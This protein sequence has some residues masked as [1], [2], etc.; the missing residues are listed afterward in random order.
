MSFGKNYQH[1][2]DLDDLQRIA[3]SF[4]SYLKGNELYGSVGGGFITGGAAPQITVGT[5]LMRLRRL[6]VLR[7]NLTT[8]QQQTLHTLNNQYADIRHRHDDAFTAKMER[9]ALSRLKAMSRFFEECRQSPQLCYS[10]YNPEVQR[11]TITQEI[12]IE[13]DNMGLV[14]QDIEKQRLQTDAQLRRWLMPSD[15][16][17]D[18]Q[19]VEVYPNTTF[20]W[21]WMSPEQ[22]RK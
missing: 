9:E 19:L 3:R 16:V 14:N 21:M 12:L 11:R 4:A 8:A 17:W 6:D 7:K 2:T 22:P 15:F 1:A 20:W 13:M 18:A 5:V 10:L